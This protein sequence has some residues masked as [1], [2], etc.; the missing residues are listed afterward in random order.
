MFS[1]TAILAK[2]IS[3]ISQF[4]TKEKCVVTVE[5]LATF[6]IDIAICQPRT[7]YTRQW[8]LR[9]CTIKCVSTCDVIIKLDSLQI[10]TKPPPKED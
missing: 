8:Q 5:A 7:K 2:A 9:E 1:I 6:V 3:G 4:L 10:E